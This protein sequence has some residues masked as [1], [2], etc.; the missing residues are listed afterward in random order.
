MASSVCSESRFVVLIAV[1]V[2]VCSVLYSL[3]LIRICPNTAHTA[4]R[5]PADMSRTCSDER[6][7]TDMFCQP[8]PL[9]TLPDWLKI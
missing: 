5:M 2:N 9:A 6:V 4:Q 3:L 1:L 8:A 7:Q